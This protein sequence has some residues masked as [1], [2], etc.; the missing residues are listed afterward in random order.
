M[1]AARVRT[2]PPTLFLYI[3]DLKSLNY[4]KSQNELGFV[5]K[6]LALGSVLGGL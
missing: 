5:F 6:K 1:H 2:P 4:T 3:K